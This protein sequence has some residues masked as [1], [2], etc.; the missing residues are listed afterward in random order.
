MA[1]QITEADA[2]FIPGYQAITWLAGK[3]FTDRTFVDRIENEGFEAIYK[4]CPYDDLADDQKA[5]FEDTFSRWEMRLLVRVWWLV[6]DHLR[7]HG[8]IQGVRSA[9]RP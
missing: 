5:V 3:V 6:Y 1:K 2:Q 9:W 4:E 7:K 8:K